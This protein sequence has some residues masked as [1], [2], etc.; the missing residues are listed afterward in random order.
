MSQP[1]YFNIG[2][3]YVINKINNEYKKKIM[4]LFLCQSSMRANIPVLALS[5]SAA[6]CCITENE[7]RFKN[8]AHIE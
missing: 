8:S 7:N 4:H 5:F 1:Q 3:I 2:T 6:D